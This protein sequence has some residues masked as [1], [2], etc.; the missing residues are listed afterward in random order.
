MVPIGDGSMRREASSD[1]YIM[2]RN[3]VVFA[4]VLA[5]GAWI[6]SRT[7]ETKESHFLK[8]PCSI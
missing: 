6:E 2:M 5:V 3:G 7:S 1:D 8:Q 4:G